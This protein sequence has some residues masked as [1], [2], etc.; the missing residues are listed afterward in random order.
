MNSRLTRGA[1]VAAVLLCAVPC[2]A[3][4]AQDGLAYSVDIQGGTDAL[5]SRFRDASRLVQGKDK[6]PP[7]L[8]GLEQ[9]AAGDVDTFQEVLRSEGYYDASV[10]TEIKDDKSPVKVVIKVDPGPRYKLAHCKI[11]YLSPAPKLAPQTCADIGLRDGRPAQA[12]PIIDATQKLITGLQ[13]HGRPAA[14][15]KDR[16][17]VVNHATKLMRLNFKTDPGKA[18]TFGAVQIDGA[19]NTQHHFL[20]RIV[21]WKPGEEYDARKLEKYRQRLADLNLF[22][23]LVV[24]PETGKMAASGETPIAVQAHER[25]PHSVA[26]GVQYAT[27]TGPGA[28]ASW[29]DR[30]LWGRAADLKLSITA[31]TLGQS[32]G[33][34]LTLPQTPKT[35]QTLGFSL[36]TER[37]TTDAYDLNGLDALAQISTPLGGHW[38]GKAGLGFEAADVNQAGNSVGV[39]LGSLPVSVSYDSTKSLL[40]PQDGERLSVLAKPEFGAAGGPRAFLVLQS[41]ASAYRPLDDKKKWVAAARLK[42]GT[43]LFGNQFG[44]P[45]DQRFYAG[46][47]G[48]VRGYAYQHVSPHDAHGNLIGG[49]SLAEAS[50]EIRY[51]A[52]KNI[53][54]VGFVDAGMVSTSPYFATNAT[55][56]VGAGVGVRYYTSFGPL[57]LDIATPLNP[58]HGD[59]PFQIYISLGQAF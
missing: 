30:N 36:T 55:P 37:A 26:L 44:I 56:R 35:G 38:T 18:A 20:A 25:P 13:N 33:A 34:S 40:N 57:R 50:G 3:A 54:I 10:N 1:A 43:I 47:G 58:A 42:L 5:N 19:K 49:R 17:A 22:D 16:V 27:D 7:G 59:S 45:P 48:S 41:E 24:K 51:R 14:A 15:V 29:E 53:G 8:A 2:A 9:R 39:L 12:Q 6:P 46:G 28:S 52:F 31:G 32:L 21:P 4:Y 11:T 23:T